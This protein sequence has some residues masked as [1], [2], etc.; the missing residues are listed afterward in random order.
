MPTEQALQ[1]VQEAKLSMATGS[2]RAYSTE[3]VR[4]ALLETRQLHAEL[5]PLAEAARA[6]QQSQGA[7]P[8]P[9]LAAQ[10]ITHHIEAYRNKRCLL[11]YHRQRLHWLRDRMWDK[12]GAVALV[13]DEEGSSGE[14]GSLRSLLDPTELDWLRGYASLLSL[15]K[16][17][18][19]DV[20]DVTLPVCTGATAASARTAR[21]AMRGGFD[22][23][24]AA[25]YATPV[26]PNSIR[27]PDDL[28]ISVVVTRN[29]HSVE[30]E[31]GTLHLR[32]GERLHV[33]RDEVEALLLRGWLRETD[34]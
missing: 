23:R 25:A 10:L 15:Y 33:R 14:S 1:L 6:E 12:A 34:T 30:T 7:R 22:A 27:P 2:L 8:D 4:L 3:M 11:A 29:A 16:E 31:R 26:L 5:A 21:N 17:A 9:A 20:L 19:L 13:L 18:Y 24:A 32:A 28:M